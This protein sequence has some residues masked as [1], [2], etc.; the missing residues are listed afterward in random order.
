M[1]RMTNNSILQKIKI[2]VLVF[3]LSVGFLSVLPMSS[4]S[5]ESTLACD[6][7]YYGANDVLFF[8][9][10]EDVCAA[11]TTANTLKGVDNVEKIWNFYAGKGLTPVA[12]AGIMGNFSQEST[13]DPAVKQDQTLKA[14]PLTGDGSTGYGIAQW[15]SQGRQAGLFKK[16]QEAGLAKYLDEGWGASEKN[17]EIPATDIDKLLEVELNYS[18]EGDSTPISSLAKDL[19]AT[20]SVE[21]DG[22]STVLFHNRFEVSADTASQIQERVVDALAIYQKFGGTS[23]A[24]GDACQSNLTLGGVQKL[25]DAIAWAKKY[26]EDTKTKYQ[27]TLNVNGSDRSDGTNPKFVYNFGHNSGSY[28]WN[29]ADCGQCVALSG[30]FVSTQTKDSS[31]LY[32]NGGYIVDRYEAAGLP[33]GTSPRPF[34]IFSAKS[35][36]AG[37]TGLVLGVLENGEV[38]TAEANWG[39]D[40]SIVVWQ[41][42]I[43]SRYSGKDLKFA[44]FDDRLA[45]D[46]EKAYKEA[47]Q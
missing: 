20:S 27:G 3:V 25:D 14:I 18:W 39:S 42:N 1:Y 29:A 16:M 7:L 44:Y 31:F 28:C 15:T 19:N 6:E 26:V 38:I 10:C 46:A 17:K 2:S 35:S 21:G 34:S 5:A 43:Q 47:K 24:G 23:T 13:F 32:D 41:G 36:K 30:W 4:V 22:G 12:I 33:T 45:N 9:P 11:G 40:G 37:H 8:N